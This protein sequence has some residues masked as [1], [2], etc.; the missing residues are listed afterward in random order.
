MC[1]G[2]VRCVWVLVCVGVDVGVCG[3]GCA[4]AWAWVCVGA[5]ATGVL[6][7]VA[8]CRHA[9]GVFVVTICGSDHAIVRSD[10]SLVYRLI[11]GNRRPPFFGPSRCLLNL[12]GATES[13]PG[14]VFADP[15]QEN[16]MRN[17]GRITIALNRPTS[18][19]GCAAA[20]GRLNTG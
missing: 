1:V 11:A 15:P 5:A 16:A 12:Q 7:H 17:A 6:L 20:A 14:R 19:L 10:D 2:G 18:I 8:Q 13:I 4:C 9:A 3:R